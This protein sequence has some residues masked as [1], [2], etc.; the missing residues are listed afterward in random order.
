MKAPPDWLDPGKP[1]LIG[2]SGGR[3]SVFL[4]HWLSDHGFQFLTYCHL[5]HGLR[6]EE[7]DGDESF[8]RTLLGDRLLTGNTDVGTL[9]KEEG[10]SLEAAARNARHEFF[11]ECSRRTGVSDILLAH[12]ADDQAETILFNLLRGSAGAKGMK[13]VT[14]IG[15]L[16]LL[17]PMLDLRRKEIDLYLDSR[18]LTYR[19]DSSNQLPFATRNRLR[20]E[21]FPLLKDILGRDPVPPLLRANDYTRELEAIANES[22]DDLELLDPQGRLFLPKIR[23]LSPSL[24]KLAIFHFLKSQQIP[25][26]SSLLI[27]KA[28]EIIPSDA[29]PS[30]SLPGGLRLRRKESRLFLSP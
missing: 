17:R 30:L 21:A 26:L 10:L 27:E 29:P 18:N 2:I 13:T 1:Y 7:S 12:H 22:L 28:M 3:D 19:D 15:G 20:H 24:Q 11:H 9:A 4:H 23:K 6:D 5:N 14:R 16:N 25:E 8:L